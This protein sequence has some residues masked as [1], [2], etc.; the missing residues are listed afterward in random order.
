VSS[1]PANPE[2]LERLRRLRDG[3]RL[4]YVLLYGVIGW[5][6]CTA[7][8]FSLVMSLW[9]KEPLLRVLPGALVAFGVGGVFF[10]EIMWRTICRTCDRLE[11]GP[12]A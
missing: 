7:V 3:G 10:G 4:R 11:R 8:L 6:A 9:E 5:G 2:R 1:R 12:P